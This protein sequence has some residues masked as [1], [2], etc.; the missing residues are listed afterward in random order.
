MASYVLYPPVIDS[1]MPAFQASPKDAE[2]EKPCRV[3]F[4]FSNFNSSKDIENG[5]V[6]A[7]IKYQ[8]SGLDAVNPVDDPYLLGAD[9]IRY[10]QTGIIL[11]IKPK[12]ASK[13]NPN[14]YY[15]ELYNKDLNGNRDSNT[16]D[17]DNE[18]PETGDNSSSG[19]CGW[20]PGEIYKIQIRLSDIDY[21]SLSGESQSSWLNANASH[22]S[23]WS[24]ICILKVVGH[25]KIQI[26]IMDFDS[27]IDDPLYTRKTLFLSTLDIDGNF[28]STEDSSERLYSYRI[29]IYKGVDSAGS[30]LPLEDSG[31][32]YSNQ[33]H[34]V[35]EFKYLSKLELD[36]L[37]YYTVIFDFVTNNDYNFTTK[38]IFQTSL[39]RIDEAL[40]EL[41]YLGSDEK[42][43]TPSGIE[44]SL[45]GISTLDEEEEEGRIALKIV[46]KNMSN[47]PYYGN[48]YIRRTSS[49]DNYLYWEDIFLITLKGTTIESLEPI[50]DYT[51]ES[52]VFYKYGIQSVDTLGNRGVLAITNTPTLRNFNFSYLLGQNNQQLKLM[53]D[54]TMNNYK[55]QLS[56][57]KSETIGNR[58]PKV[59]RNNAVYYKIFP[60]NGLISYLMD[61]NNLFCSDEDLYSGDKNLA[62]AYKQ[63]N[64]EPEYL[65]WDADYNGLIETGSQRTLIDYNTGLPVLDD[66]GNPVMVSP[67]VD[68]I[69]PALKENLG[70]YPVNYGPSSDNEL[71]GK[72]FPQ[73]DYIHEKDFRNKVLE[74]LYD[75]QPKLFKSPT[76]GNV[77]VR[78]MDINCTPVQPLDRMIYSFTSNGNEIA[79]NTVENYKKYKFLNIGDLDS[80]L[81]TEKTKIGQLQME[82]P[83]EYHKGALISSG[84]NIIEE[85]YNKHHRMKNN[86]GGYQADVKRIHHIRITVDEKPSRIE[87][88]ENSNRLLT[89]GSQI[90][91]G[92]AETPLSNR[93]IITIYNTM[94]TYEF[95][96]RLTFDEEDDIHFISEVDPN[97]TDVMVRATVDYLYDVIEQPYVGRVVSSKKFIGIPG[98]YY[99]DTTPD[100]Q[101]DLEIKKK[102]NYDWLDSYR[103]INNFSTIE[104]QAIP[105][106]VF[107]IRDS[108]DS[109][110][111]GV[112]ITHII[113]ETGILNLHRISGIISI[114]YIGWYKKTDTSYA[115]IT[116]KAEIPSTNI[117]VNYHCTLETGTYVN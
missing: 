67:A 107:E 9:E 18:N 88:K 94:Q 3:Y 50:Y 41:Y 110:K 58:Y 40:C 31:I 82:F 91:V 54:N 39:A 74:F 73:Y 84:L 92:K 4:S 20:L 57:S 59:V 46:S 36:D 10:R 75:G 61:S 2:N 8:S 112:P 100:T 83:A 93:E 53:F 99:E 96:S 51:I 24:T 14:L 81:Y 42:V 115:L 43:I 35:N 34:D 90:S 108:S 25:I 11:N 79:D 78:L 70:N 97:S 117:M 44:D 89:L 63:H 80:N 76:E 21:S 106:S 30:G 116:N 28:I 103:K 6:Q 7:V 48:F 45:K 62:E 15:F 33:F 5:H 26:P 60:V 17:G 104:I 111:E 109:Y 22:F 69:F 105:N 37:E 102:Y 16:D 68:F 29:K 95:D 47:V 52:G 49:K 86:Y 66:Q 1:Y 56:E 87:V 64:M 23:E 19:Y 72:A 114:K 27:D 101:I 12:L 13:D 71:K 85:I 113:N 77:I 38:I 55:I 98:Q 65:S 32:L